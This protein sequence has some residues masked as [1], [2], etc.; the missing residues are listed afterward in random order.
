MAVLSYAEFEREARELVEMAERLGD[1]WELRHVRPTDGPE[2][3]VYLLKKSSVMMELEGDGSP[4]ELQ[5]PLD[6]GKPEIIEDDDPSVLPKCHPQSSVAVNFEYHVVHSPSYQAPVLF[7]T[8]T[9][10]SGKLV[11]LPDIWKSMS[12]FHV[13]RAAGMEWETVTQQEHPILCRPFYHIHP[14]HTP[15]VMATA[16]Q[17]HRPLEMSEIEA[18]SGP[19]SQAMSTPGY[20]LSWLAMYGPAIGL[21]VPLDYLDMCSTLKN[22]T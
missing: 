8:A 9:F 5:P 20:L 4:E 14:C 12:P 13:T 6:L 19:Q 7:F 17:A 18:E 22:N 21:R 10:Q 2:K 15:T 11:P 3:T 1:G 16:L